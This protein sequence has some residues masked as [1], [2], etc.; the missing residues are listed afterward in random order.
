MAPEHRW[1]LGDSVQLTKTFE[2]NLLL[3]APEEMGG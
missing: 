2:A 1:K 3:M